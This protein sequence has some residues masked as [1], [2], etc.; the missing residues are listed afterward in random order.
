[1]KKILAIITLCIAAGNVMPACAE[2]QNAP[3]EKQSLTEEEARNLTI[4]AEA[5]GHGLVSGLAYG[6]CIDPT[7]YSGYNH[8]PAHALSS[9]PLYTYLYSKYKKGA[10]DQKWL[11]I[12]LSFS[13]G[14]ITGAVS[15]VAV[16]AVVQILLKAIADGSVEL[17]KSGWRKIS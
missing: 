5:I 13:L 8:I 4:A 7:S 15:G 2:E 14:S 9:A 1:M 6:I 3:A 17:C 16:R 10:V 11:I 12:A